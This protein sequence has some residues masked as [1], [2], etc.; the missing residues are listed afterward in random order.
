MKGTRNLKVV[1]SFTHIPRA[2]LPLQGRWLEQAGFHI[3]MRVQ[4]VVR[5]E[6]LVILPSPKTPEEMEAAGRG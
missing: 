1:K 5:E 3:G 4:V 2:F 6:C